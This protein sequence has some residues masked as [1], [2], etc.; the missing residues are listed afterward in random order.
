MVR[1]FIAYRF[2]VASLPFLPIASLCLAARGLDLNQVLELTALYGIAAAVLVIPTSALAA[3]IG[4]R[5]AMIGGAITLAIGAVLASISH[6]IRVLA[7]AQVAFAIASAVDA[8]TDSAYL[9]SMLGHDV[10]AYR[11]AEARSTAGKLAGGVTGV[12]LGGALV[13]WSPAAPFAVAAVFAIGAALCAVR[14]ADPVAPQRED[15]SLAD[16]ARALV[17]A[18]GARRWLVIGVVSCAVARVMAS[19]IGPLLADVG[20]PTNRA[21]AV[22]TAAGL[23]AAVGALI[24]GTMGGAIRRVALF[25]AVPAALAAIAFGLA[26]VSGATAAAMVALLPVLAAIQGP[27][28]RAHLNQHVPAGAPRMLLLAVDAT[29]VRVIAAALPFVVTA[30]APAA[31]RAAIAAIG[32]ALVAVVLG[33]MIAVALGHRRARV[34]VLAAAVAIAPQVAG[35]D[36]TAPRLPIAPIAADLCAAPLVVDK[37]LGMGSTIKFKARAGGR[38]VVLRPAQTSAAG[39]YRADVA[40]YR[41]AVAMGLDGVPLA[42]ERRVTRAD[43]VAV[44]PTALRARLDTEIAW[45]ADDTIAVSVVA[46]VDGVKSA[47]L[48]DRRAT[49]RPQLALAAALPIDTTDVAEGSRLAVWDFLIANWDRW[50]GGNTFRVGS[51]FVWL[52]NAAGFGREHARTRTKRAAAFA[53]TERF[54]R[55]LITALRTVDIDAALAGSGL[56]PKRIAEVAAR[57]DIILAHVDHVIAAHGDDAVLVFD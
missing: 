35:A 52:D 26:S 22:A 33:V 27:L 2:L 17:I 50:S 44:A 38:K 36:E 16:A 13:A 29:L 34:A 23:V 3:R 25:A 46:W 5:R 42:C 10:D 30:G 37:P 18:A 31:P 32:V 24:A 4:A 8:G 20:L 39:N 54:S 43:L 41:L 55:S 7:I 28:W 19:A 15:G 1:W 56:A 11:Q 45:A 12:V 49:W 21:S 47:D 9:W 53:R 57:R 6:D 40:A 48:E 14:L 51:R